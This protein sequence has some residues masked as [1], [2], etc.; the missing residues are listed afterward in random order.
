MFNPKIATTAARGIT[1]VPHAQSIGLVL[2]VNGAGL[3]HHDPGLSD[4]SNTQLFRRHPKLLPLPQADVSRESLLRFYEA[5]PAPVHLATLL[6]GFSPAQFVATALLREFLEAFNTAEGLGHFDNAA[7]FGALHKR[8]LQCAVKSQSLMEFWDAL[9]AAMG[10]EYRSREGLLAFFTLPGALQ[11]AALATLGKQSQSIIEI[12]RQWYTESKAVNEDYA[13]KIGVPVTEMARLTP[14]EGVTGAGAL[15]VLLPALSTNSI[16]HQFREAAW[17]HFAMLLGIEKYVVP[18]QG[19]LPELVEALFVN[20]GNIEKGAKAPANVPETVA[21][22]RTAYPIVDAFSG[23]ARAFWFGKS[24]VDMVNWLVCREHADTLAASPVADSPLL[25]VSAFDMLQEVT[26]TRHGTARGVGQMIQNFEAL[27]DGVQ[28]YVEIK[29]LPHTATL[30]LGAIQAAVDWFCEE[31]A[32]VGGQSSR[33]YGFVRVAVVRPL[34]DGARYRD[35]YET[36]VRDNADALRAGLVDGTLGTA[37]V[38][39]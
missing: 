26:E 9:A 32:K 1:I 27:A 30:T 6:G 5:Q 28:F 14:P 24:Q 29:I 22:V 34:A 33:G 20:G 8:A 25:T 16:R 31:V 21:R 17:E 38:I 2:T 18:G 3:S 37:A 35:E 12:A 36:Y 11:A 39:F 13:T 15:V 19:E 23:T 4:G 10:G 7:K